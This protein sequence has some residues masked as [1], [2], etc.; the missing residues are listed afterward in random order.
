VVL[1]FRNVLKKALGY[2]FRFIP[3]IQREV[4]FGLTIFTFHDVSN[5]PSEFA[6]QYGL[7]VS[8]AT[9]EKQVRWIQAN[10]ELVHPS[11]ILG[12]EP[13]PKRAAIISFD[14][15]Y[16]GSFEIGLP[17]LERL[18]A[19]SI[20]F[21]NMQP[22]LHGTALLSAVACFL[23]ITSP[24]F[25]TICQR[26]GLQ[27]PFHLS[28]NPKVFNSYQREYGPVDH[29]AVTKFQGAMADLKTLREWDAKPLV[30]YGNHLFDHWNAAALTA[31]EL[32]KQYLDNEAALSGLASKIN[33]F[34][35]TNGQPQICFT[36]RDV[37][38][39][40]AMGAGKVFSTA[41]GVNKD[42]GKFLQGRV[43][44]CEADNDAASL[45]F[46][47]GRAVLQHQTSG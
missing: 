18:G 45:W 15:G 7:V 5:E 24:A 23:D 3:R 21:L 8:T 39:L 6:S 32:E 34:A 38:L 14:D 43:A 20:I 33:L 47:V 1:S 16:R 12:S 46:R 42:K 36:L 27:R 10:F 11:A 40:R 13:L 26:A 17:I 29:D 30:C 2:S 25:V 9:F 37:E 22:I 28:L 31:D 44:L 35:F 19:P 4:D 41:A